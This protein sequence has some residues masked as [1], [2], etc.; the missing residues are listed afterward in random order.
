MPQP[1]DQVVA[2]VADAAEGPAYAGAGHGR[3]HG[4]RLGGG[5]RAVA[6]V[7]EDPL[8]AGPHDP[9]RGT[10]ATEGPAGRSGQARQDL[11]EALEEVAAVLDEKAGHPLRAVVDPHQPDALPGF[12]RAAFLLPHRHPE[13]DQHGGQLLAVLLLDAEPEL[14]RHA[15]HVRGP[16]QVFLELVAVLG[17][18]AIHPPQKTLF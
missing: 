16:P 1:P 4:G 3:L 12:C 14:L 15:A 13:D 6:A 8:Q 18:E 10:A 17:R 9:A 2:L 5:Q 7:T 11:A